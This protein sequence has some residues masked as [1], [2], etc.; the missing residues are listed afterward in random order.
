M[1]VVHEDLDFPS[2][3]ARSIAWASSRL[4]A[5]GFSIMDRDAVLGAEFHDLSVIEGAGIN[6][7]RLRLGGAQHLFEIRVIQG[8]IEFELGCVAIEEAA[9][10]IADFRHCVSLG[11]EGNSR[12]KPSTWP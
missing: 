3:V 1:F 5:R 4:T 2:R 8:G 6:E 11:D 7:N 12:G 10:W 9:I